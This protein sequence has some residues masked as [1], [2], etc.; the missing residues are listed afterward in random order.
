MKD[1]IK[2]CLNPTIYYVIEIPVKFLVGYSLDY[3]E[4]FGKLKKFWW[5]IAKEL[6][7]KGPPLK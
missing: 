2:R 5:M 7:F 6:T 3:K 4:Q 1:E